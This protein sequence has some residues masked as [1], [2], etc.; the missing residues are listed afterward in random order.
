MTLFFYLCICTSIC[1]LRPTL[2]NFICCQIMTAAT[3]KQSRRT[4]RIIHIHIHIYVHIYVHI[5]VHFYLK[6]DFQWML[7]LEHF[8]I[9][10]KL[11]TAQNKK[12]E[13]FIALSSPQHHPPMVQ[14]QFSLL[15]VH[16]F[17][18]AY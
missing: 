11:S 18:L 13:L 10:D 2:S 17:A 1:R 14:H 8:T 4:L 16:I 12:R 7:G 3:K 5:F 6:F 9:S 15:Y